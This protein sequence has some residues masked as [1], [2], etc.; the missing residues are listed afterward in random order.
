[1]EVAVGAGEGLG[2]G[3]DVGAGRRFR[4]RMKR[5]EKSKALRQIKVVCDSFLASLSFV[6]GFNIPHWVG[7]RIEIE[8][9]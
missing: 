2:E 1:M 8:M 9:T 6:K 4:S 7:S 5:K 3:M